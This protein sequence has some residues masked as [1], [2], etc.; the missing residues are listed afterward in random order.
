M[1]IAAM[2]RT[3]DERP[4]PRR[5]PHARRVR[6]APGLLDAVAGA[7]RTTGASAASRRSRRSSRWRPPSPA[8]SPC[9]SASRPRST[10]TRGACCR[11][12]SASSSCRATTPGCATSARRSSSTTA[13]ALRG[14]DWMFNAWGGLDGG[15]YFPVGQG[16]RGRAEGA[17]DRG[18]RPL[19]RAVRARG[20]RDPR[21]RAGH[22]DHHRGVPAQPQPQSAPR[23][24]ARSRRC[25]KR[26][27]GVEAI[28]WLGQGVH[29]DETDGHVDNLCAFVRPGEVV[30]TWTER[31]QRPAVRDLARCVRAADAGARRAGPAVQG[32]QAAPARA[33][34][35]DA[36]GGG[37]HRC[38]GRLQAPRG[39]AAG[40]PAS[41]VNFYLGTRRVVVPLLD[42]RRDGAGAAQ[43]EGA[44][45]EARGRGRAG[46]R[47]PARRRQHPLRHAAGT[48][49]ARPSSRRS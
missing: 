15:L 36:R 38:G 27:L 20:R 4:A 10:P 39:A 18:L 3:L 49:G 43:A 32:A 12:P 2:T 45:S 9:R 31:P 41:Y 22:A 24:A 46:P 47:D 28:V 35:H 14:V 11:P 19:P 1:T 21:G 40:S 48:A 37:R 30:L 29:L 33:A 6:A 34:A 23:R 25:C 42:P 5:L 44:V 8:A 13:A 17:R 16:R 7:A 26:Y